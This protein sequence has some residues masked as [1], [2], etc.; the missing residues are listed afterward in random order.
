MNSDSQP[1][2][3]GVGQAIWR[4]RDVT[5]TPVDA[6]QDVGT[7]AL[8]NTGSEQVLAA[9]DRIVHVP[10]LM[11][12]VPGFAE[13][14]PVNP[15]AALAERLGISAAQ[16]TSDVG[17]N[18]PQQ[19]L[20][21]FA[22]RLSQGD[23]DVVLLC[24]V[25]LLATFLGA[26]RGGDGFPDWATGQ[27]DTALQVGETPVM[28]AP[29]EQA[30][31]LYEPINAY[32][33][34]ESAQAHARGLSV[35]EHQALLGKLVSDMSHVAAENPYAWKNQA[36]SADAV[37]STDGGNRMISHPYTKVMNAVLAVDQAAAVVLT[38][39]GKARELN[40]DPERWIYLRG[41]A[42]AHDSWYLGQR[43]KLSE[44]PALKAA[45]DGALSQ[46]GLDVEELTHFDLYSCF[47][48]AV[49]AGCDALGIQPDD[50][51]GVTVT[52]GLSLFGGPGN[53]YS[54]HGIASMA[55][56]LRE[57]PGG[58]GLVW[59]NGGYLTKHAVGVYAREPGDSPWVPGDDEMLQAAIDAL[60]L[61]ELVDAG[62]GGFLLEAHTVT[63]AR[64][65]PTRAIAL[66]KLADGRRCAAVSD[67][68]DVMHALVSGNYVG[69]LAQ[70]RHEDGLNRFRLVAAD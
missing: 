46:S 49:Q 44:S 2:I 22:R 70:V 21:E 58:A 4:E 39:V 30:H 67:D 52:G 26:V 37:L 7:K 25:E 6:L 51:R 56:R 16:F 45:C 64:E 1:I 65:G 32:P 10:F 9:I 20:N 50:P 36:L 57:T 62:E 29:T 28:T 15:G 68:P 60:P 43:M 66:G 23:G 47:P 48:A 55:D 17:G 38:T 63:Y 59:A 69:Q 34:F 13:A 12:Q 24:G 14:M 61:V 53:N 35:D 5:R 19:L 42:S 3:I 27:E 41:A 11:N 31:G 40:I 33:L 54:L 18:L 8:S